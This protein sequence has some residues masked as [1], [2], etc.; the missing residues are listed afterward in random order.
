MEDK[1]TQGYILKQYRERNNYTVEALAEAI[2]VSRNTITNWETNRTEPGYSN[3]LDLAKLYGL[4]LDAFSPE[5]FRERQNKAT[6]SA[7]EENEKRFRDVDTVL[8][9]ILGTTSNY[10]QAIRIQWWDIVKS[11]PKISGCS[12]LPMFEEFLR[13]CKLDIVKIDDLGFDVYFYSE[14]DKKELNLGLRTIMVKETDFCLMKESCE[15]FNDIYF[16]DPGMSYK[17]LVIDENGERQCVANS[18][19]EIEEKMLK[20]GISEERMYEGVGFGVY[21]FHGVFGIACLGHKGDNR[22]IFEKNSLGGTMMGVCSD[23]KT[24]REERRRL[25]KVGDKGT[26]LKGEENL[27]LKQRGK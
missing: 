21:E 14:D 17:Y 5:G 27:T 7:P 16:G 22:F 6:S 11:N 18:F 8:D 19:E 13:Q 2:N 25:F 3:L 23:L 24:F 9:K 15:R 26:I 4:S 12:L 10:P 20:R 1:I